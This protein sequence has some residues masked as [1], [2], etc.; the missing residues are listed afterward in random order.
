M[1][2][3]NGSAILPAVPD[4]I[5]VSERGAKPKRARTPKHVPI[6]PAGGVPSGEV[7]WR[8]TLRCVGDCPMH[9]AHT[10]RID[11]QTWFAARAKAIAFFACEPGQLSVRRA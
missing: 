3:G 6:A 10:L 1:T 9:A 5:V 4:P 2:N 8:A 11:A 7:E